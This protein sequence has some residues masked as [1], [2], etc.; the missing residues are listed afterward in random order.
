MNSKCSKQ[1]GDTLGETSFREGHTVDV[2][3]LTALSKGGRRELK[4]D[5][6]LDNLNTYKL[7][8]YSL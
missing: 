5:S 4:D 3:Q 7:S 1:K 2:G 8:E 6:I